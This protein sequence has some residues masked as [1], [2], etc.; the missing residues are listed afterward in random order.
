VNL[1]TGVL[2]QPDAPT[3]AVPY[4]GLSNHVQSEAVLP[5]QGSYRVVGRVVS[6][7]RL[8]TG[9]DAP[10]GLLVMERTRTGDATFSASDRQQLLER[11]EAIEDG[12]RAQ[13]TNT[14]SEYKNF[15]TQFSSSNGSGGA[16][17]SAPGYNIRLAKRGI[18]SY[19]LAEQHSVSV[20]VSRTGQKQPSTGLVSVTANGEVLREECVSLGLDGVAYI[21]VNVTR[22]Q[23]PRVDLKANGQDLEDVRFRQPVTPYVS[24]VGYG[25]VEPGETV[26]LELYVT[27]YAEREISREF[28]IVGP[29]QNRTVSVSIPANGSTTTEFEVTAPDETG[30]FVY[31]PAIEPDY[32]ATI[33]VEAQENPSTATSS[34]GPGF[35]V[36]A[37]LLSVLSLTFA[38]KHRRR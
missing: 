3:Q 13:L 28:L 7:G 37:T 30:E 12:I 27:N 29:D 14:E 1:R 5:E 9:I 25:S 6:S 31:Y 26:D 4:V 21:D 19:V 23:G 33:T 38:L 24:T 11:A 36:I 10:V 15:K 8:A 22:S 34:S 18:H 32:N 16:C 17:A 2:A 20:L 35:G